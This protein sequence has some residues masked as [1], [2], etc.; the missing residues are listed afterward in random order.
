[1]SEDEKVANLIISSNGNLDKILGGA[2]HHADVATLKRNYKK[3]ALRV[4][5]DKNTHADASKAFQVLQSAFEARLEQL[6]KGTAPP[7]QTSSTSA[8]SPK[9][10]GSSSTKPPKQSST[11]TSGSPSTKPPKQTASTASPSYPPPPPPQFNSQ[12][13]QTPQYTGPS[14]DGGAAF[15]PPPVPNQNNSKPPVPPPSVDDPGFLDDFEL[16]PDVFGTGAGGKKS[17]AATSTSVPLGTGG[18]P[19]PPPP[20]LSG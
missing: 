18:V 1:M 3:M 19:P 20:P 12:T 4:H 17:S 11:S 5:P 2:A 8:S 16:P 6:E 9:T 14:F 7:K 10:S 13:P 15:R